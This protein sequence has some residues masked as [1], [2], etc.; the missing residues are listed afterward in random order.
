M[1]GRMKKTVNLWVVIALSAVI[2]TGFLVIEARLSARNSALNAEL[3]QVKEELNEA[4]SH[5]EELKETLAATATDAY[6][7]EVART[8]YGY[9]TS[10]DIRLV[11]VNPEAL[12]EGGVV[13]ER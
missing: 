12:Y 3:N 7:E 6:V 13:P 8:Q 4:Q 1:G 10:D 9:M 11:I 5:Q 2:L